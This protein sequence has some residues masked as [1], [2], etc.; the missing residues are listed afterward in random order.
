MRL[1]ALNESTNLR[2][3][4]FSYLY[5]M[6]GIPSGFALTTLA[7]YFAAKNVT[8][9]AIGTFVAVVGLPWIVQFI[10]GPVIDRHQYSSIG[11]RKHWILGMQCL[12]LIA[13]SNLIIIKDPVKQLTLMSSIFFIHSIFASIQDASVDATAI[14]VVPQTQRGRINAFMR[15][16]FLF[17]VAIGSAL[18]SYVLHAAGFMY[19]VLLQSALLLM[20]TIITFFIKIN[21]HDRLL[22]SFSKQQTHDVTVKESPHLKTLFRKLFSGIIQ[23]ASLRNFGIIAVVYLCFSIFIR[24]YTYHLIHVLKWPDQ[25]VSVLQGSW[26]SLL[27]FCVVIGGGVLAD[28]IGPYTLQLKVMWGIGFY[29]L[30]LNGFFFLWHHDV[31]TGTG[32]VL[33]N[34]VDPMFSVASFPI[35]MSLCLEKVEGSQ[36]TAY[37][38]ML[39]LCDVSGSYITGWSLNVVSAP[40]LGFLCGIIMI[41][42][43]V[44]FKRVNRRQLTL[45]PQAA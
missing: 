28:K 27:T 43:I 38:A 25:S 29:L 3:F 2:Y 34:F 32:L 39:N 22:P 24:G 4:T 36:F 33:W 44:S 5:V 26:G 30:L 23:S 19:A 17:G 14:S 13:I 15:G 35:L 40:V 9:Q 18:L 11:H 45:V 10:W 12:A 20:F 1:P 21:P 31:L 7:N 42:L 41:A 6:Q 16:G 8:P 37:M